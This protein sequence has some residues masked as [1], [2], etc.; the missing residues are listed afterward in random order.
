VTLIGESGSARE[1]RR[2]AALQAAQSVARRL[3][4]PEAN[5]SVLADANNT[6]IL[7]PEARAVAKVGT[8][9]IERRRNALEQEL[10]IARHLADRDAPIVTPLSREAAGPHHADGYM[11][12]LW[13][14]CPPEA[15]PEDPGLALGEA[16]PR[17][18][19]ALGDFPERLP[20]L[21]EKLDDAASLFA[22]ASRTPGLSKTERLLVAAIYDGLRTSFEARGTD[23]PLHGGPHAGN[24]IW[25]RSAPLFLDFE[26]V[27]VG[28]LE[29]DLA[30]LPDQLAACPG[31]DR[32]RLSQCRQAISFCTAAWCWAQRGRSPE[33]DEAAVFHLEALKQGGW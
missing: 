18:H 32:E 19:Q 22:D 10:A 1:T 29:W 7:L 9:T 3:S 16:L 28:P 20:P 25:S 11:L 17:V 4:L 13:T 21:A 24:I 23:C 2:R 5:A 12:T 30:F 6:L 26:A 14:Y 8:S 15:A 31:Y 27:C 33:V